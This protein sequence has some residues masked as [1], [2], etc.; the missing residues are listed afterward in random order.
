MLTVKFNVGGQERKINTLAENVKD[1][2]PLFSRFGGYMRSVFRK[3]IE[4]EGPGWPALKPETLRRKYTIEQIISLKMMGSW[5]ERA[6]LFKKKSSGHNPSYRMP[7]FIREQ[8]DP[9][10]NPTDEWLKGRWREK[11][12]EQKA[13]AIAHTRAKHEG[14]PTGDY[15]ERRYGLLRKVDQIQKATE[16]SKTAKTAGARERF[17]QNADRHRRSI[18]QFQN[19]LGGAI[20]TG[21]ISDLIEFAEEFRAKQK[22]RSAGIL[23]KARQR[24]DVR[25]AGILG[26]LYDTI[27]FVISKNKV[28]IASHVKWSGAQNDGDVVGHGAQ[29][30]PRPFAFI[31]AANM[32]TLVIIAAEE[33][34]LGVQES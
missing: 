24:L 32:D 13:A 15:K 29:L 26:S 33:M 1:L 22:M 30:P 9:S 4:A 25:S 18:Q 3:R 2:K 23:G 14:K 5:D 34:M 7:R 6:R 31:E 17:R 16:R 21:N 20:G 19:T 10:I 11:A 8:W 27:H 28:Q 12:T